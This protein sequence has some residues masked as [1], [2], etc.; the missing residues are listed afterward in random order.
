MVDFSIL[1]PN[2]VLQGLD[3]GRRR[4]QQIDEARRAREERKRAEQLDAAQR[5]FAGQALPEDSP[6]T[7]LVNAPGAGSDLFRV[8]AQRS[9]A[10]RR[11][12]MQQEDREK[13]QMARFAADA[14]AKG[15]IATGQKIYGDLGLNVPET[16]YATAER[17]FNWS[18][19]NEIADSFYSANDQNGARFLAAAGEGGDWQT[20]LQQFPPQA[21]GEKGVIQ[22]GQDGTLY[23]VNPQD[24]TAR[25][26]M[27]GGQ[28]LVGSLGTQ[29]RPE[30]GTFPVQLSD[31]RTAEI[32]FRG[33]D[34]S[35][36]PQ[37]VMPN[38]RLGI[39]VDGDPQ[40]LSDPMTPDMIQNEV[41]TS[42]GMDPLTPAVPEPQQ[43]EADG[44]GFWG[45]IWDS[46]STGG[47]RA[48]EARE[49]I[50]GPSGTPAGDPM[51][52]AT[53]GGDPLT[54]EVGDQVGAG[55]GVDLEAVPMVDQRRVGEV[56]FPLES[57]MQIARPF[58]EGEAV[59]NGAGQS[60]ELT[61]TAPLPNGE[62]I[63]VPSLWMTDGG[64]VRAASDDQ[65]VQIATAYEQR[66]GQRFPRHGDRQ[67]AEA[68]AQQ[69]SNG[70]G[71]FQGSLAT[72]QATAPQ[73]DRMRNLN[74]P[75]GYQATEQTTDEGLPIV[76]GPDG[77]RYA[78][79]PE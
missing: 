75:E 26:V 1:S 33:Y 21:P 20:A 53:P 6:F 36:N 25:P 63:T 69:R 71:A 2:P 40:N 27:A 11:R 34:E 10:D 76:I 42:I 15:D 77:K 8:A 62:W 13:D 23:I 51:T 55:Q 61:I 24:G 67:Q 37:W 72:P 29:A 17:A 54:P 5:E 65:A 16:Y 12:G 74:L 38:G 7:P 48:T 64:P 59:L 58:A 73:V 47:D 3:D 4:F 32:Q 70:G 28:P 68:A 66:T 35:G 30:A 19:A 79:A 46:F 9:E 44:G 50:L 41:R 14:I 22:K 31:G 56:P 45:T 60:T 39:S 52:P 78:V 18:R 49:S 57:V 43:V